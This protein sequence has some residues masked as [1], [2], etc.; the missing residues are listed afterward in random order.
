MKGRTG[1]R[2]TYPVRIPFRT[3]G[4][5]HGGVV[6][7][8]CPSCSLQPLDGVLVVEAGVQGGPEGLVLAT[9]GPEF[10]EALGFF[11]TSNC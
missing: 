9:F 3:P 7:G 1:T 8:L 6:R 5:K 4:Q 10:V 2:S 11:V